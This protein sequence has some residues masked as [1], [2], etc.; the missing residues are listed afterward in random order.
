MTD[1]I[2]RIQEE[3]RSRITS[4][5][6]TGELERLRV[7]YLGKKGLITSLMA[8]LRDLAPDKRREAGA[9]LNRVKEDFE[10]IF[11]TRQGELEARQVEAELTR[12]PPL[13]V[14]LPGTYAIQSGSLHPI[15]R[16][17]DQAVKALR[18]VGFTVATGP[19]VELEFFNF[20]AL[21]TPEHHPARDMQDT[22]YI[23]KP[24]LL[25]SH[26]S[27]V[28]IRAMKA[29]KPPLQII[30]LGKVYRSDYDQTH[31]PMFHQLEGLMVDEKVS[32]SHL[33]GVMH[34]LVDELFGTRPL[35]FRPSYFPFV[36]PG[37]EVDML[38]GDPR[39]RQKGKPPAPTD[40]MEIGGCGMVHPN[41]LRAVGYDP[42]RYT[43]FAFGLGLER[44]AMIKYGI[45]DLRSFF[46]NDRRMLEQF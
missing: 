34:Y 11:T 2:E 19:E 37:A 32:F 10:S 23:E 46:E 27:P 16:I 12:T 3:A 13:D 38:W 17:T 44:M 25:R 4:A 33:K 29:V 28:Q 26:T 21:N 7:H 8:Q 9:K 40:W 30:S 15:T 24:V 35:R 1:N 20:E 42:D 22:F 43:G 36:E 14:T 41:V 6:D 18:K 39:D 5:P 45:S 31:T